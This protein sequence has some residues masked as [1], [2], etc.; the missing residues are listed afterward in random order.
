MSK[1]KKSKDKTE[2][3]KGKKKEKD[4]KKSTEGKKAALDK[5]LPANEEDDDLGWTKVG[6]GGMIPG[7]YNTTSGSV[8]S[9]HAN[10]RAKLVEWLIQFLRSVHSA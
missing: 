8:D 6:A 1:M 5:L 3:K 9:K 4:K 10:L 7:T 2:M